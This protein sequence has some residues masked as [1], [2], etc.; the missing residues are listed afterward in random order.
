MT[1]YDSH[2]KQCEV[3]S[4]WFG[5][6]FLMTSNVEHLFMY[7][8]AICISSLENCLSRSSAHC[9]IFFF[10]HFMLSCM[11]CLVTD[12][13]HLLIIQ[14]TNILLYSVGSIPFFQWFPLLYKKLSV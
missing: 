4:L 14:F 6:A 3:V 5:Y 13:N 11:S 9:L 12:T 7:L 2:I 1:L 8:S 10:F